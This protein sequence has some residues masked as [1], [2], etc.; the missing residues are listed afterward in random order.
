V[1]QRN[2]NFIF[3]LWEICSPVQ[4]QR[5]GSET[6]EGQW[7]GDFNGDFGRSGVWWVEMPKVVT[8]SIILSSVQVPPPVP[9]WLSTMGCTLFF[10]RIHLDFLLGYLKYAS[11]GIGQ[12]LEASFMLYLTSFCGGKVSLW[13]KLSGKHKVFNPYPHSIVIYYSQFKF[14]YQL[15]LPHI[16]KLLSKQ[17]ARVKCLALKMEHHWVYF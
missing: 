7:T 10:P 6:L 8:T 16:C 4:N 13:Y 9:H 17:A 2:R 15:A 12:I 14:F 1:E 5:M 11:L 3:R